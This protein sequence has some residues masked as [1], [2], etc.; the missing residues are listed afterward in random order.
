MGIGV[1]K[2][3]EGEEMECGFGR[4]EK[5]GGWGGGVVDLSIWLVSQGVVIVGFVDF[6]HKF[7]TT[8]KWITECKTAGDTHLLSL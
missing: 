5:G 3:S 2:V 8:E 7:F 4:E 1:A 6:V